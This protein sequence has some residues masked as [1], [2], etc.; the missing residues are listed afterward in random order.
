MAGRIESAAVLV[1]VSPTEVLRLEGK[2]CV[3]LGDDS[4]AGLWKLTVD[5]A[6][7]LLRAAVGADWVRLATKQVKKIPAIEEESDLSLAALY[8]L[9]DA[10]GTIG[11][12]PWTGV[13]TFW[14]A[15][16]RVRANESSPAGVPLQIVEAGSVGAPA[17]ADWT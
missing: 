5:S 7:S 17:P 8:P 1:L 3:E 12:P 4:V 15:R 13:G 2:L 6:G 16:P 11:D 14:R 10:W 9:E